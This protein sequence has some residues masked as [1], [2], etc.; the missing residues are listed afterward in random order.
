MGN[1]GALGRENGCWT[2]PKPINVHSSN[3][4]QVCDTTS[5]ALN[6]LTWESPPSPLASELSSGE[7]VKL[8]TDFTPPDFSLTTLPSPQRATCQPCFSQHG[9]NMTQNSIW[10]CASRCPPWYTQ[11]S[12]VLSVSSSFSCSPLS[13]FP[14]SCKF[15]LG[16]HEIASEP[17]FTLRFRVT[18]PFGPLSARGDS[19]LAVSRNESQKEKRNLRIILAVS[20]FTG[21]HFCFLVSDHSIHFLGS[22]GSHMILSSWWMNSLPKSSVLLNSDFLGTVGEGLRVEKREKISAH[23]P[24]PLCVRA[25]Y[26]ARC[27]VGPFWPIWLNT[28]FYCD[29]I[30]I[31]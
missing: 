24:D 23:S 3:P 30:Y 13:S 28:F 22:P 2:A 7:T 19:L 9:D 27:G 21:T 25:C 26:I 20:S 5:I 29:K 8:S 17:F 12:C 14:K 31:T 11:Q 18:R 1:W 16:L 15:S 4:E 6:A 10:I